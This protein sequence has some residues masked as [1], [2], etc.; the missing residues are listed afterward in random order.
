MQR[1]A[2]Y[3]AGGFGRE[4]KMLIDQINQRQKTYE[5]IGYFDDGVKKDSI[6]NGFNVIGSLA[7]I[8]NYSE[9]ICVVFAIA[10][11]EV[12]S[13]LSSTISKSNI[14]FPN[15]IHPDVYFDKSL[16]TMGCG[17]IVSYGCHFTT[18]IELGN[19]NLFNTRVSVGHDV[20]LGSYNIFQP[21]V[22]ISGN[23]IIGDFNY[24]GL[25]SCILPKKKIGNRNMIGAGSV[26]LRSLEND[27]KVFGNPAKKVNL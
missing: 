15:I 4:V 8:C 19:F 7:D 2:I 16:N 3:G 1:I 20:K 22:Q 17:N 24:W 18:N 12:I 13:K 14:S 9:N 25:N 10:N 5:F 26:L 11:S 21:N 6:V 27:E 23:V